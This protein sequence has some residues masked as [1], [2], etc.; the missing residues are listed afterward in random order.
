[1]YLFAPSLAAAALIDLFEHP[2]AYSDF[3]GVFSTHSYLARAQMDFQQATS[4]LRMDLFLKN[5]GQQ[6][7]QG[8]ASPV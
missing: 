2:A 5:K 3:V 1:M 7:H 8:Y 4:P 6:G